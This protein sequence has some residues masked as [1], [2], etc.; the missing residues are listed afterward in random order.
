MA[1]R[2][3]TYLND[4][5]AGARFAIDVLER[6]REVCPDTALRNLAGGLLVEIESDR[7]VLTKDCRKIRL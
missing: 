4:H 7:A 1:D 2:L 5:L 6:M 3:A